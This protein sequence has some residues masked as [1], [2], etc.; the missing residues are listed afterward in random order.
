MARCDS[1]EIPR[2]PRLQQ[3]RRQRFLRERLGYEWDID[4]DNGFR[5]A[6]TFDLST[7]TY[8]LTVGPA[9]R[10]RRH[11][12]RGARY[13]S[14]DTAPR[15]R[16]ARWSLARA[17]SSG[18]GAWTATTTTIKALPRLRRAKTCSRPR[19]ICL[20]IW[21]CSR[22]RSRGA[23]CSQPVHRYHATSLDD[24][25]SGRR[26]QFEPECFHNCIRNGIGF[27]WRSGR[28]R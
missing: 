24:Y 5:P 25:F 18:P 23:C 19:S 10:L 2:K 28:R 9:A 22:P 13:A 16:A 7:A 6:G 17:Q 4:P 20:R 3:A 27:R 8:N 15:S 1:G 11:L 14:H 26:G 21:A 12:R